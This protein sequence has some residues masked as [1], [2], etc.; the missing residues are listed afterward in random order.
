MPERSDHPL[1]GPPTSWGL[2]ERK[3]SQSQFLQRQRTMPS[4]RYLN[5][6]KSSFFIFIF[7]EYTDRYIP[8]RPEVYS[9]FRDTGIPRIYTTAIDRSNSLNK[10]L[11][12]RSISD[13]NHITPTTP[14]PMEIDHISSYRRNTNMPRAYF[15]LGSIPNQIDIKMR[16]KLPYLTE[17]TNIIPPLTSSMEQFP[18]Q[19]QTLSVE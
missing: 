4:I 8:H 16:K 18:S 19:E 13:C 9:S 17:S 5:F 12:Y 6:L 14:D 2:V 15:Y 10:N 1:E 7:S 11:T 3:R